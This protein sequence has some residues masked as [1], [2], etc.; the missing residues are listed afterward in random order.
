MGA[1][2][3]V[4]SF[5]W[6][7]I[8]K[9]QIRGRIFLARDVK[10]KENIEKILKYDTRYID[11]KNIH[12]S[13]DYLQQNKKNIFAMIRQ[14]GPPPFFI[15]FTSAK[16]HLGLLVTTVFALYRNGKRKKQTDTLE[17]DD[18]DYLIR[19]DPVTCTR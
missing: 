15:T 4:L 11:F 7:R 17:N 2:E 3:K 5:I 13:P 14:L 6:V 19:K 8:I 1:N 18:I 9:G 16:H 12:I 10:Y